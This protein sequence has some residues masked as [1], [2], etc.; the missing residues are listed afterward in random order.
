VCVLAEVKYLAK[1]PGIISENKKL[2]KNVL[3]AIN[4][5]L[6]AYIIKCMSIS[7]IMSINDIIIFL[8]AFKFHFRPTKFSKNPGKIMQQKP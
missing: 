1:F 3:R 7:V 5:L 8:L 2:A 4:F 6:R